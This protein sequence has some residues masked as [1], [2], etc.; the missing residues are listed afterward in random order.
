M[1][2]EILWL[3]GKWSQQSLQPWASAAVMRTRAKP[4]GPKWLRATADLPWQAMKFKGD[5]DIAQ[6]TML[7][8][9]NAAKPHITLFIRKRVVGLFK[10]LKMNVTR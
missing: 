4:A 9:S 5:Q 6:P 7:L 8:L 3:A 1:L 2:G 10:C